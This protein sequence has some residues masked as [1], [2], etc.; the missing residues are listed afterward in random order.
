MEKLLT[1]GA[2][3]TKLYEQFRQQNEDREAQQEDKQLGAQ[4]RLTE[5]IVGSDFG[6]VREYRMARTA[7]AH[8][9]ASPDL[10]MEDMSYSDYKKARAAE[11]RGE[12]P[13]S[14][15]DYAREHGLEVKYP[16]SQ[17]EGGK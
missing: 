12:K 15:R 9:L 7:E 16:T 11:Q 13:Q 3:P 10:A 5:N 6:N 17:A 2:D 1:I 14:Y 8:L 4:N